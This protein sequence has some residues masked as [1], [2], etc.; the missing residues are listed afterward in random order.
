MADE[1]ITAVDVE[2]A[3]VE[4]KQ[5]GEKKPRF[6][7]GK[8]GNVF[9]CGTALFS[10]GYQNGVVGDVNTIL[11]IL[12]PDTVAKKNYAKAFRSTA[13]AGTVV[14]QLVFGYFSDSIGRKFGMILATLI[15]AVF[16]ALSAGS[17][18]GGT[19]GGMLS[20]LA[21]WRFFIGIGI[22]AEY[23][24]GSVACGESSEDPAI[25]QGIRHG[26]FALATNSAI[27]WGFVIS[28][29]VPL[30]FLWICGED[31]LRLVWRLS[32]GFGVIPPLLVLIWR[33]GMQ[34]PERYRKEAIVRGKTPYWLIIK[35]YWIPFCALSLS[36]FIY[37]FI[38]YPFGIYS[39]TIINQIIG[40]DASLTTVFGW[41]VVVNLFYIPGTMGGALLVDWVGPKRLMCI[42]LI[43]QAILGFGM[44]GGYDHLIKHIGGF[45]VAY[46]IFL[47]LGEAGPGNCLGLLAA[48]VSP[49]A[50]RGKFYGGAAAVGKIGAFVGTWVF[51]VIID[52]FGSGT[53]GQTGPF[54][55]GSG[56]AILSAIVAWFFLPEIGGNHLLDADAEFRAYLEANGYDT[57]TMGVKEGEENRL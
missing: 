43:L 45:T 34:E 2:A 49:T 56:L 53:A 24:A 22:G 46:G 55:I 31:H 16:A 14:G 21:A 18:G 9:A 41:N 47:S 20:A 51:P 12:Y 4:V 11:G 23:P 38:V 57:S 33:F 17:Y 1:K 50:F 3:P 5:A 30:V 26:L 54:Y 32:L 27:D 52:D 39:S 48:K 42:C 28:S 25:K 10:D 8:I 36:W 37:D 19:T 6:G 29:F 13:F 35:K 44:S 15:V 7:Y 40:A